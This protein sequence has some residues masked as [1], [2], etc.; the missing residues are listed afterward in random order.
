MAAFAMCISDL[1]QGFIAGFLEGEAS[2]VIAEQNAGRSYSCGV[3]VG[4][5]DDDQD[6]VEWLVALTG[7]GRLRRV[8]ARATSHPQIAWQIDTQED[9]TELSRLL[10][11]AGFHGRRNAEL[12]LWT[13]GVQIW[14]QSTG[15]DRHASL[16]S[17]SLRLK[18]ARRFGGGG[19]EAVPLPERPR[20]RLGYI[21]GLVTAEGCFGIWSERPRFGLHLRQDDRPL[22][23]LLASTTGLGTIYDHT[24]AP[25]LNPSS[26]WTIT[27]RSQLGQLLDLLRSADVPGRKGL[28]LDTWAIA[29]DELRSAQRLGVR[30]RRQLVQLAAKQ[31]RATRVYRASTRELLALPRR[32]VRAES[33]TALQAWAAVT[34]GRLGCGSYMQWRRQQPETPGRNTVARA[35]G[36]WHA[37]MEAA[38]LITRA[39]RKDKR[40]GGEARRVAER[41]AKRGLVVG[42]VRRFQAEH[43]RVPRAMEFFKWRFVGAPE[44]PSQAAVYK[45]FPGGWEAVLDAARA[46]I[47]LSDA[48]QPA[49]AVRPRGD[50]GARPRPGAAVRAGRAGR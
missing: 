19:L 8:P 31:L 28:E 47:V 38:G 4:L 37:A 2:F 35:F 40:A 36:S 34:P 26:T 44:T 13:E 49:T 21:S 45:L 6:L 23:G 3:R 22:L 7:I 12:R 11:R 15:P 16:R 18:A 48:Q 5:R 46:D 1:D 9:C 29:V 25:P 32:D 20:Q 43:G 33:I 14:A 17:L 10:S 27:S 41:A 24:P 39:A 50:Q 30:P 42:A